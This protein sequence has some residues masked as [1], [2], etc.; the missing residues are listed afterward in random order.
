VLVHLQVQHVERACIRAITAVSEKAAALINTKADAAQ[1]NAAATQLAALQTM[2][3]QMEGDCWL[4][5]PGRRG[6]GGGVSA[7][8][9]G[10]AGPGPGGGQD[11][12]CLGHAA[13]TA[14]GAA[15]HT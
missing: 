3:I 13:D 2:C 14:A 7:G 10:V 11:R 5:S 9:A 1:L 4:A 15:A 8:C 12:M 6:R